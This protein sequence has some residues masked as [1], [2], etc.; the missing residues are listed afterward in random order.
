MKPFL[1]ENKLNQSLSK[2]V[3]ISYKKKLNWLTDY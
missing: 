2:K 1:K 3:T